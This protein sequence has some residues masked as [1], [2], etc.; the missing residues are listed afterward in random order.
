ML[1]VKPPELSL[2]VAWLH[3]VFLSAGTILL[4]MHDE[5][6]AIPV[7]RRSARFALIVGIDDPQPSM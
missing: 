1:F 6:P 4:T 3:R 2:D 5:V 7:Y